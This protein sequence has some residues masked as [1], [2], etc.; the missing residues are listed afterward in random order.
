MSRTNPYKKKKRSAKKTILIF[1]EGLGEEMI[2]KHLRSLYAKDSGVQAK[3]LKGRGGTAA[4]I[5]ADAYR[6]PGDF[7]KVIVVIDNDKTR[8]EME[9]AR[10]GA[11]ERKIELIE[12][13]PCLEFI[14]LLILSN[15]QEITGKNSN[16]CKKKFESEYI[17]KKKRSELKEYI[18]IFPKNLLDAKRREISELDRLISILEN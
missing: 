15:K 1:G 16:W 13:T 10:R 2:L 8:E 3:I 7:D 12:H 17:S 6:T 9:Q 4:R 11:K 5:V 14:L 18:K